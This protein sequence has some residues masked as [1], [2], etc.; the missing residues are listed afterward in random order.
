VKR[1]NVTTIYCF[2]VLQCN[3]VISEIHLVCHCGYDYII[4]IVL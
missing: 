2:M 1:T 3:Y 4:V